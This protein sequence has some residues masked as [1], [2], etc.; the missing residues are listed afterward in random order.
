MQEGEIFGFIGNWLSDHLPPKL[1]NPFFECVVCM[2]PWYGSVA[3]WVL[4]HN[5]VGDWLATVI[6]LVGF[7]YIISKQL[8][9]GEEN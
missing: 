1:H 7:N 6:L 3:Y 2:G 4:F 9:H 8:S 5:S